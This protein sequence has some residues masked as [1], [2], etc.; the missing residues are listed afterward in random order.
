MMRLHSPGEVLAPPNPNGENRKLQQAFEK[1]VG[2]GSD[3]KLQYP[4]EGNYR[5]AYVF[6][7][8]NQ[9]GEDEALVFYKKISDESNVRLN[10]LESVDGKWNSVLDESGYGN[11]IEA[12]SFADL[13]NDGLTEVIL[14]WGLSGNSS[15]KIMTVHMVKLTQTKHEFKTLANMP[16]MAMQVF[17][18]DNDGKKE[19][20]VIWSETKQKVPHNH[21]T[22]M[23]LIGKTL[24]QYGKEA[25]L[26]SSAS[27][28]DDILVQKGTK[29]I[30]FVEALKGDNTMFTEVIWWDDV[31]QALRAPFT[32]NAT[33]TNHST[34][35]AATIS[36]T[37]IDDDGLIEIPVAQSTV[38]SD[39]I[40]HS[41]LKAG[42]NE[43][44]RMPL[45]GWF[46]T[47]TAEPGTLDVKAYSLVDNVNHYRLTIDAGYR[48][49][50]LYYRNQKTGVITAYSS[51]STGR[52]EPLFSLVYSDQGKPKGKYSFIAQKGNRTVTGSLTSAGSAEGLTN[53][54]IQ[55]GLVIY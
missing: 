39:G 6:Y 22:L 10:I 35:R 42:P 34:I 29:P 41:I 26:D 55:N 9:D 40:S 25:L 52:G 36:S 2:S 20:L 49:S 33:H 12:V 53:K 4:D 47:G 19:I 27:L 44:R 54:S 32:E 1:A 38:S 37:D 7:D 5:S 48:D 46:A 13:D 3:Y 50:I 15:S 30:A 45:I 43:E 14:S 16:Y 23:K 21:A 28:Y 11:E 31:S 24:R 17:D 8:L 18:I 51:T